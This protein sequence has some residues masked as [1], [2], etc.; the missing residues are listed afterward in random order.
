MLAFYLNV[1]VGGL[2]IGIVYA[3]IALGLNIIFGVMRV[4][5]FAHGEMVVAGMYIGFVLWSAL[6]IPPILAVPIAA[7][8]SF[9]FGYALQ[10]FLIN[11]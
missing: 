8:I 5:N 9:A 1:I 7:I 11:D 2:L 3:L 10:H 6:S 4:V